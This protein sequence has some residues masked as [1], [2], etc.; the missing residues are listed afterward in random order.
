MK[1]IFNLLPTLLICLCTTITATGSTTDVVP[2][3]YAPDG[4]SF[5]KT[6][7][8]DFTRQSLKAVM[9][10]SSCKTTT[11]WENILSVGSSISDWNSA[12][13]CNLHA[14]YT[15][16]SRT[17]QLNY[18]DNTQNKARVEIT[19]SSTELTLE[20]TQDGLK[21]NGEAHSSYTADVMSSLY[22][23]TSVSVGSMQGDNRSWVTYKEI[24]ISGETETGGE[25]GTGYVTPTAGNTY[26]IVPADDNSKAV[27]LEEVLIDESLK[28]LTLTNGDTQK[29][30]AVASMSDS[31][32]LLFRS[33]GTTLVMDMTCN[34]TS[35]K[36]LV[37][38]SE[39]D[40]N[41]TSNVNQ[42]FRLVSVGDNTYKLCVS[43]NGTEYYLTASSSAET[44]ERTTSASQATAFGFIKAS[45]G[46][47]DVSRGNFR[48]SW[49]SDPGVTG[50]YKEEAHATF[51]PYATTAEMKADIN[52]EKPWLTPEKAQTLN[53]N[54]EW[55]FKY[56]A[57]TTNGPGNCEFQSA[58]HDDSSW[59]TI[60][61]PMSWEMAGYGKPVYT[62]VGYAFSN[63]PPNATTGLTSYGVTDHNATGFYR[64]TFTLP[65][66]WKEKRVFIH[67]DGVYSAA[68]VWVNGMFTGYSQGANTD[69]E[70]DITDFV[71]EGENQLS[72]CVYRWC[73][74]SY[75]EGQDMWHLSGIHRD[76][77]L[78]ATPKTF[79]CDHY[80][81]ASLS[82]D[83]TNGS[84][85]VELTVDN[86]DNTEETKTIKVELL[87]TDG[88]V[89]A[90]T[91]AHYSGS[92]T[93]TFSVTLGGLSGLL[94]WTS[95]NPYLYTV[96]ISQTDGN[97]M[98]EMAFS[99]RY[100][101]RTIKKE[102]PLVYVNG[103]RVFF[104]G[105]NTQDSHPALGRAMDMETLLKDVTM[106]KQANV[107]TIRTSHY[108]RQPKMYAMFDHYGLYCMD[109]ADVE[110]H[111]NQSLTGN[112][113]WQAAF[114]D[115]NV[116]MVKRDRNHPSVV[117]WSLGNECGTGNNLQAAYTAIKNIDSRLIHYEAGSDNSSYSDLFSNMYPTIATVQKYNGGYNGKPYFI[118]EYAHAMGQAVGNLQ[119]YWDEIEGSGGIIGGCIW[120]WVDQAIY[121]PARLLAGQTEQ[122]GT[123]FKYLTAGYDYQTVNANAGFQGNFMDNGLITAD[124]QWT[125]KLTEVK[126]VY[127]NITFK[128]DG[129]TL[130]LR[131]KHCFT[132]LNR[133]FLT[134]TMLR[135]GYIIE[136][137]KAA[138]PSI[139]A[140]ESGNVEIP[141]TT[142]SDDGHDYLLNVQIC[143][144]SDEA[145]AVT[146]YAVAEG[147]FEIVRQTALPEITS[148]KL[149]TVG[150]NSVSGT[151]EDGKTFIIAFGT[152]GRITDWTFG[153]EKVM[154]ASP[155]YNNF[156][157]IDNNRGITSNDIT[158]S[159]TNTI[160]S[161]LR[162]SGNNATMTMTGTTNACS[163]TMTYTVYPNGTMDMNVTFRPSRE[164]YRIG[165]GAE[166]P[167]GFEDVEYYAKGPWSN[168]AD[169]QTGSF[170]GR[171]MTTVADM[172]EEITHPQT[173]GDHYSLR[174]LTLTNMEKNIALNIKTEGEVSFSLSHYDEQ[175]WNHTGD[176]MYQKVLHPYGL[177]RSDRIFAHF[178]R[179]QRGLGNGS[180][181][182]DGCLTQYLCPTSG[183]YAYTLRITP[184]TAE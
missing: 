100:G 149:L 168:Y 23:L 122:D 171:Y 96:A 83:A 175:Q 98:E 118:C 43:Y 7:Q 154:L 85:N 38:T 17:L 150:S 44:M 107:N 136:R 63:N 115:R 35:L 167:A 129:R 60:N 69:A 81:T 80:I 102:G 163:Y 24:S 132:D 45:S 159:E 126:N 155:A 170:L 143:L 75:L 172:F 181:G 148:N 131:N 72:V 36:P 71:K 52:Y 101:F 10:L 108:P 18:L 22:S 33:P 12:G 121:N 2:E 97:G 184:R 127:R 8:I 87:D 113:T 77:Y 93:Q 157:V 30:E 65:D 164:Q 169:R 82:D 5:S 116:R 109:E 67:F 173:M 70:F 55:K 152:N 51:I 112:T 176:T 111:G 1:R 54:G 39:Y 135:D 11:T 76:V 61:V 91:T 158:A 179:F 66:G 86:R 183:S 88:S 160:T 14:Y 145:W 79:V 48:L 21:I 64:R 103:K 177:T 106:M 56:V 125:A 104:K 128:L 42:E 68:A 139:M 62:N 140:G 40:Y 138:L 94:P 6:I 58:G 74:G 27:S 147:Q 41:N 99:T 151:S 89:K 142:V 117:F 29:W 34:N 37:W 26:Y 141:Y 3:N 174:E 105:V 90:T 137:G 162:K 84:L 114:V 32:P 144:S 47:A 25:T 53:L 180:C 19:L 153:G 50:K 123:G 124:R 57:G 178:D 13:T 146:G 119:E 49:I 182:G 15:A 133:Y 9:N 120:D 156:R 130:T 110:C 46:T 31:Y 28:L 20:L 59:E 95:E 4:E 92:T 166:F 161:S 73:D 16:S 134:W 165:L 78:V